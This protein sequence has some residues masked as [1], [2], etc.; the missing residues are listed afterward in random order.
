[1]SSLFTSSL[2]TVRVHILTCVNITCIFTAL[3]T[4]QLKYIVTDKHTLDIYTLRRKNV[5]GAL[6]NVLIVYT[7]VPHTV[8]IGQF[9]NP[10]NSNYPC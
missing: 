7:S 5:A 10:Y 1:M 8:V 6:H 9:R 2:F 3:Q 4:R